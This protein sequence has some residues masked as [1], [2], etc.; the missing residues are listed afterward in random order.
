M[1]PR[2]L[3]R[4]LAV[5]RKPLNPAR[6]PKPPWPWHCR[7]AFSP[8]RRREG[9]PSLPP[10]LPADA[11]ILET[12]RNLQCFVAFPFFRSDLVAQDGSTWSDRSSKMRGSW[13]NIAPTW[14]NMGRKLCRHSPKMGQH[15]P[16]MGQHS[17]MLAPLAAILQAMLARLR[18][19]LAH[20]GAMLAHASGPCWAT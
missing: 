17:S 10:T 1:V 14:P 2:L 19:M 15:S 16:K 20:V 8:L 5:R 11:P 9:L 13:P 12:P 18:V 6:G 3:G 7:V 4:R